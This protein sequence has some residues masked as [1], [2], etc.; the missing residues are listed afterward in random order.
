MKSFNIYELEQALKEIGTLNPQ[1]REYIKGMFSNFDR[2]G[3]INELEVKKVV[4]RLKE[5]TSD[6]IDRYETG[7]VEKKLLG[8]LE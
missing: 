3:G 5:D 8:M 4:K 7:E 1:Q 2:D 6:H